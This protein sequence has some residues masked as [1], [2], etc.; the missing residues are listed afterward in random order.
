MLGTEHSR[1]TRLELA[2]GWFM[3]RTLLFGAAV[4]LFAFR[5][6]RLLVCRPRL[7][8]AIL[9][10]IVAMSIGCGLVAERLSSSEATA[11]LSD[12]RFWIP[13]ALIHVAFAYRSARRSRL[14]KPV[15]LVSSVPPP[16]WWVAL[17]GAAREVLARVPD[18]TGLLVGLSLG[19]AYLLAV[20]VAF[21]TLR[22]R[23]DH[24]TALRFAAVTHI[25]ALLLVP[26]AAILDRPLST[27]PV[28]WPA[29]GV[30]MTALTLLLT[31][32]FV[33]HRLRRS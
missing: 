30:V 33:W 14:V 32:S 3:D 25:C 18:T 15:D 11:W 10:L 27:Q 4:A 28:D 6:A 20:G 21:A 7:C 1:G 5:D 2:C 23:Q 9:P 29:T 16:V 19:C 12:G 26:G 31:L 22:P 24:P 17:T 13:A 8:F